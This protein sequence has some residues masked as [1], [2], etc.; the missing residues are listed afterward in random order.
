[1]RTPFPSPPTDPGTSIVRIW[2]QMK[3]RVDGIGF[4]VPDQ[5]ILT[6]AHVVRQAVGVPAPTPL[7]PAQT[8]WLDFPLIPCPTPVPA[9]IRDLLDREDVALLELKGTPPTEVRPLRFAE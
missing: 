7:P 9:E 3:Q 6:C 1:M 5:Q 8:L 2:D 4:L